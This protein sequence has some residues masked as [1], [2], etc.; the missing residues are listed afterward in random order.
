MPSIEVIGLILETII[1]L[2]VIGNLYLFLKP[3]KAKSVFSNNRFAGKGIITSAFDEGMAESQNTVKT[4]NASASGTVTL[5]MQSAIERSEFNALKEKV[6]AIGAKQEGME[7]RLEFVSRKVQGIDNLLEE[8][9]K[10]KIS[11]LGILEKFNRIEEF[12]RQAIIEIEALKQRLPKEKKKKEKF[13]ENL[14]KKIHRLIFHANK[15]N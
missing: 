10:K 3:K 14:E 12:R 15:Q 5:Q 2:L 4:S 6:A 8:G 9:A 1:T 13:D 11:D 7:R